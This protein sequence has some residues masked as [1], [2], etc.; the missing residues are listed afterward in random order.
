MTYCCHIAHVASVNV[1]FQYFFYIVSLD[2]YVQAYLRHD[3]NMAIFDV[4][5]VKEKS[6]TT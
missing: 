5:N 4:V 2:M 3:F 6:K 1:L